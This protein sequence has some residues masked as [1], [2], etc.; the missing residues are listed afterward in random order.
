[1]PQFTKNQQNL[2]I[3]YLILQI[4]PPRFN[5]SQKPILAIIVP[6]Y[7]EKEII[8]QSL[9]IFYSKLQTLQDIVDSASFI[10]FVDDGSS[11]NGAILLKDAIVDFKNI[12]LISL[13]K[14]KGHQNALLCGYK[15]VSDKCDCAIS[16]DCDLEQDIDKIAEFLDAFRAGSE[17]VFGVREDRNSDGFFKKFSAHCFYKLMALFGTKIIKNHADYRLLSQRA[18]RL[19]TQYKEVNLFL[20]GLVVELGL[21]SS[22]VYFSVKKRTAGK[23][24]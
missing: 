4:P 23:S 15:F 2:Q 11:D 9:K 3:L 10:V 24:K 22:I 20:R 6:F 19:I 14:N 5:K 1:M 8:L 18:L 7:N 21:K 13:D 17:I 16:V 12:V